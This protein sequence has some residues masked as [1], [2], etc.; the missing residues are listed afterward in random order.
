M[1]E[2]DYRAWDPEQKKMWS[3]KQI[4]LLTIQYLNNSPLV[5]QQY[6]GLKDANGKK[7]YEGDIVEYTNG[8]IRVN[9]V[10][11]PKASTFVVTIEKS[12]RYCNVSNFSKVSDSLRV[13]GSLQENPEL[14]EAAKLL[15]TEGE[16]G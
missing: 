8:Q 12:G 2:L 3:P 13:I 15:T 10:W 14:L 6:T 7:I 16:E 11:R 9:G 1:S 4:E 5:L